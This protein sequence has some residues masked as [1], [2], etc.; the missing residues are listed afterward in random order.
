MPETAPSQFKTVPSLSATEVQYV[1]VR[2]ETH[3]LEHKIDVGLGVGRV[4]HDIAIGLEVERIKKGLPQV[5]RKVAFE[6]GDRT[7]G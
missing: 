5:R 7:K 6:V 4:L 1:V 2:L 3:A